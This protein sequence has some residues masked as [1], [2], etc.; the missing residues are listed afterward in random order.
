MDQ[1]NFESTLGLS[2]R[3][4]ALF[5]RALTHR[6]FL[7]DN[8][9]WTGGQ[10]ERLEFLGDAVIELIVSEF[11]YA[12]FPDK[13][14]G[15]LTELRSKLVSTEAI[16][17]VSKPFNILEQLQVSNGEKKDTNQRKCERLT[18]CAFEAIVG[19]LYLDQGYGATQDFIKRTLLARLDEAVVKGLDPKSALQ[20]KTQAVLRLT[21]TYQTLSQTG[22][23][24]G[25]RF[26]VGVYFGRTLIAK[27]HGPSKQH[28]EQKAA[29]AAMILKGWATGPVI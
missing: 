4:K 16:S 12:A 21:P 22:P 7:N 8:R 13:P 29:E 18:A 14:E 6:S 5:A 17:E 26:V 24:H 11:I 19:A 27:G 9:W 15:E 2:F 20:E 1:P 28:A 3:D 10:N 25:K 23:D